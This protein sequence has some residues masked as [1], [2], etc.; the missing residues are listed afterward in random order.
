MQWW[1]H[2]ANGAKFVVLCTACFVSV[3]SGSKWVLSVTV[4]EIDDYPNQPCG[5]YTVP[6]SLPSQDIASINLHLT[7]AREQ[8]SLCACSVQRKGASHVINDVN[9]HAAA[10][11]SYCRLID[12]KARTSADE[13]GWKS[14]VLAGRG[15]GHLAALFLTHPAT[16]VRRGPNSQ[17]PTDRRTEPMETGRTKRW[18]SIRNMG[19]ISGFLRQG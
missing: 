1:R 17:R 10:S 19:L 7:W 16:T 2:L 14:A 8:A 12:R 6:V 4:D 15:K 5:M 9:I 11:P 13:S 18:C 3:R